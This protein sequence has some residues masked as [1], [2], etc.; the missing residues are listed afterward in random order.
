MAFWVFNTGSE[1]EDREQLV[2][3]AQK[4]LRA[5]YWG[6]KRGTPN[7]KRAKANHQVFAY[8]R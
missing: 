1:G 2:A 5:E 8:G 4:E 6:I 7:Y 3:Q